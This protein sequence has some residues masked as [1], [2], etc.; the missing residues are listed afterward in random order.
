MSNIF[1]VAS[2]KDAE[3]TI[4]TWWYQQPPM[5]RYVVEIRGLFFVHPYRS[6]D[7]KIVVFTGWQEVLGMFYRELEYSVTDPPYLHARPI[8]DFHIR[9][10]PEYYKE[11]H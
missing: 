10:T 8:R 1:H 9:I 2:Y 6:E 5:K 11:T 7:G 3:A 4:N